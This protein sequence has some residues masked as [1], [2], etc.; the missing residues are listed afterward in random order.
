MAQHIVAAG[1]RHVVVGGGAH[2]GQRVTEGGGFG[3]DV[4]DV[5]TLSGSSRIPILF[6][7]P[8][9]HRLGEAFMSK[10]TCLTSSVCSPT[11][12]RG[13]GRAHPVAARGR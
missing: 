12:S 5:D 7:G 3:A 13:A 1:G 9:L 8:L 4:A 6:S 10:K 11:S 2:A